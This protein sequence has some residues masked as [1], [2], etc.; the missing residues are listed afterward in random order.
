M[1]RRPN[2]LILEFFERG[3][4]LEDASNRYQHTCKSCGEKVTSPTCG[5][6]H[7]ILNGS[8][9]AAQFPKGRIDSLTNHLVKKCPA[10]P[11]RDRQ[12]AVLQ[13]HDLP[14]DLP[15]MAQGANA[16]VHTQAGPIM[17]LP[18]APAKEGMSALETLAEVS[19]QHLDLS[20][21]RMP[22]K[23]TRRTPPP[24][25]NGHNHGAFLDEFII[26]D[27]RPD[28]HDIA[29]ISQAMD[30][31][32]AHALPSLY[33]FNDP[34]QHTPIASP[35]LG[36]MPLPTSTSMH[37]MDPSLVMT[38]SAANELANIMPMNHSL[39]LENDLNLSAASLVEKP[40]QNPG[41]SQW[42]NPPISSVDPALHDHPGQ[43][44]V[45]HED[46]QHKSVTQPRPIAMNP[47]SNQTHFTTDFSVNQKPA[48][49]KVRG[50]F[51]DLRRK[52]V[53]E[54]RK[55]GACI[56][57]RMLKKPC[58]GDSPCSTCQNVESARLWK[59]PCIRTRI[60]DEFDLYS[61]GLHGILAFQ[62]VSQA[63]GQ[64]RLEQIHGRIEASQFPDCGVFATFPTLKAQAQVLPGSDI[65]PAI[66][67]SLTPSSL[68]IIDTD[69][70]I[71]GKID[72]YVKKVATSFFESEDSAFMKTTTQIA[73]GI[74]ST[75]Q[76]ALLS[77]VL[78]LWNLTRMLT[79][80]SLN[81]QLVLNPAF[82]PT[83][84]PSTMS[85]TDL[86][87]GARTPITKTTNQESFNL[88]KMQLQG[89]TEK[90]AASLARVVMND[91]E[92]RLLQRQQASP[93]ETFLIAVVLLACVERMCW[94]YRIWEEQTPSAT[95]AIDNSQPPL[96]TAE[97]SLALALQSDP[98]STDSNLPSFAS[99]PRNPK[100]PFDR[101][102]AFYSQQ[103]ERFS[104][105]LNMLLKMRG[106]PPRPVARS[107]D[108]LLIM[109][110]EDVDEKV[111]AW[112]EGINV[113]THILVERS[114]TR[115]TG[116]NSREWELKYVGKIIGAV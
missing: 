105:I 46:T 43:P 88:I 104:D 93:F 40:F 92:R 80:S 17:N 53:Q 103:G 76:D 72:L 14:A 78:E 113:T 41:R 60:A 11:L 95:N 112:Y 111:R 13:F 12:R 98:S 50:R 66:L 2:Q 89:A 73:L 26:Q 74:T 21:K 107:T 83:M 52:E 61:A 65:D 87:N 24:Q 114:N 64:V 29:A 3:P 35:H 48:K 28:S 67:A 90:R 70:D 57:C 116:E 62:A 7:R 58:S 30:V 96:P 115:F 108:G 79:S 69:D 8:L 94:L 31:S 86:E 68:E 4:K 44:A 55:R 54:V 42:S 45:S 27:D 85:S 99:Y 81:W 56:R 32:G 38:A 5:Q 18:F 101:P 39:P 47:G 23:Q 6:R 82:A 1:G 34:L 20:G 36:H 15:D 71:G 110:G 33:H 16:P 59:Q 19:R 106:V 25:I 91:L 10:L 49:P 51:S 84:A 77:K 22:P 63:K 100:W 102:P 109:W 97:D 75:N 9:T 37:Q